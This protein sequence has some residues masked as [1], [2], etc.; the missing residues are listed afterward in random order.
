MSDFLRTRP[1]TFDRADD[2]L[3]AD[4]WFRTIS[5]KLDVINCVGRERVNLAAHQL[6]GAAAEW[7]EN[8]C[9]GAPNPETITWEEF[10]DEFRRYHVPGGLVQ[11]K[12]SEFLALSQGAMTVNQYV[13]KF[14]ALSRYA[15][16]DV[17]TDKKK[18]L[19]FKKGLKPKLYS[20]LVSHIYP[21]FNTLVSQS[22]LTEE[23]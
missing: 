21:D 11:L 19:M 8:F 12:A 13:R 4:S 17:N 3:E 9:E 22:V 15:P 18:Q 7:W 20:Q 5:Q 10:K 14:I 16:E 1:P 6:V 2:P 23:G